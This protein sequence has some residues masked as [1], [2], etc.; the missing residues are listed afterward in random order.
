MTFPHVGPGEHPWAPSISLAAAFNERYRLT[1]GRKAMTT[2]DVPLNHDHAGGTA[3]ALGVTSATFFIVGWVWDHRYA[4]LLSAVAPIV[5][6]VGLALAA[7]ALR[8]DRRGTV[9]RSSA[10]RSHCWYCSATP[11]RC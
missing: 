3:V 2:S 9:R 7:M 4:P 11:T 1:E 6:L 10:W 5:A 8:R